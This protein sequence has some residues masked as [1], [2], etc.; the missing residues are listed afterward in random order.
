MQSETMTSITIRGP[1]KQ[2]GEPWRLRQGSQPGALFCP[3]IRQA[4]INRFMTKFYHA[5]KVSFFYDP[6]KRKGVQH[7]YMGEQATGYSLRQN[8]F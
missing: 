3:L 5:K 7:T 6:L 8:A 2:A 4:S 1:P